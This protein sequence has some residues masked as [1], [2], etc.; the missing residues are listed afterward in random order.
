MKDIP[1]VIIPPFIQILYISMIILTEYVFS[2]LRNKL[3]SKRGLA[4]T[5]NIENNRIY[6]L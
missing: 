2:L 6:R 1:V 5:S 4:D 3:H